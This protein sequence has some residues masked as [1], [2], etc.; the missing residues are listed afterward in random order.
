MDKHISNLRSL[1][2]VCIENKFTII[3]TNTIITLQVN[4]IFKSIIIIIITITTTTNYRLRS[5]EDTNLAQK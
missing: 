4:L 3:Y 2:Q 1:R 5:E